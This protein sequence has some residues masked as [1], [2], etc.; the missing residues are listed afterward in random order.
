MTP[1]EPEELRR[2]P[3]PPRSGR[4]NSLRS[5]CS[6]LPCEIGLSIIASPCSMTAHRSHLSAVEPKTSSVTAY[7]G[8]NVADA[9][10][11]ED[12]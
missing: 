9:V 11:R 5:I 4:S 7:N 10:A 3:F 8:L 2:I 6:I 12:M 1:D